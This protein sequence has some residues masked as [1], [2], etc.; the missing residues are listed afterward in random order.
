M[1]LFTVNDEG[2]IHISCLLLLFSGCC[3]KKGNQ[4][5]ICYFYIL[6]PALCSFG[7]VVSL[8]GSDRCGIP[9]LRGRNLPVQV[10]SSCR[11]KLVRRPFFVP[12]PTCSISKT[13]MFD[14][15]SPPPHTLPL[16]CSA[17]GFVIGASGFVERET[18][19]HKS[20]RCLAF[21]WSSTPLDQR[22]SIYRFHSTGLRLLIVLYFLPLASNRP[23]VW[24]RSGTAPRTK[25]WTCTRTSTAT[26][27][28]PSFASMASCSGRPSAPAATP[29][30]SL[31]F[32]WSGASR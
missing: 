15:A 1:P 2:T 17:L 12:K 7:R 21:R 18:T 8:S 4:M 22:Y 11:R 31:S 16:F 32:S 30:M 10:C 19:N 27:P 20:D 29:A 6:S 13:N 24:L 23:L 26:G 9:F 28:S 3:F 25:S 14:L 5:H